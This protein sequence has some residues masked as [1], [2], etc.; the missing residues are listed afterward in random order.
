MKFM[1]K[2]VDRYWKGFSLAIICLTVEALCDLMQPTIM[3]SIVDVGVAYRD[4][5]Y[6]V[7]KGLVM[8]GITAVGAIGASGRNILS[9]TVSQNFSADLREDLFRKVQSFSFKSIDKFERSS[10]IT[11]LTN[12]VTQIQNFVNSLMRIAVK[13]PILCVGSIIMA[14]RLN[15]RLSV[16]IFIAISVVGVLIFLNMHI[17]YPY[18]MRVQQA[19][20]KVNSVMREYLSG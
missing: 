19:L 8:L 2:Y 9:G 20:D 3:S 5:N 6:I 17:G 10:L 1:R 13:A 4:I 12:D 7:K 18:F 15:L 11:R 16:I 14:S